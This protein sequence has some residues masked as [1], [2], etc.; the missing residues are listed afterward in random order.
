MGINHFQHPLGQPPRF[1]TFS[2]GP[3]GTMEEMVWDT[4]HMFDPF[5]DGARLRAFDLPRFVASSSDKK[6][7]PCRWSAAN[8][9]RCPAKQS[10][11]FAVLKAKKLEMVLG[12]LVHLLWALGEVK[13]TVFDQDQCFLQPVQEHMTCLFFD[14]PRGVKP[15]LS[16]MQPQG[17]SLTELHNALWRTPDEP[18]A[19]P[20]IFQVSQASPAQGKVFQGIPSCPKSLYISVESR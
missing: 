2:D 11:S 6:L 7:R 14:G 19:S 15:N 17:I 13:D 20:G 12:M 10:P 8:A 5:D 1:E 4:Y 3:F 16:L 18:Q 9:S